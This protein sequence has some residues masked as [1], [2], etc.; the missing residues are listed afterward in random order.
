M[1]TPEKKK[2][3][4]GMD[5]NVAGFLSYLFGFITGLIFY[6]GEKENKF[7]RFHALQSIVLSIAIVVLE[8]VVAI[9]SSILWHI[10]LAFIWSIITSIIWL[11]ILVLWI[12]LMVKAYQHAEFKLPFIGDFCEKQIK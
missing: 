9:I 11:G 5:E 2:T 3:S 4:M 10:G 7:V 12:F 1:A 6:F 8:I